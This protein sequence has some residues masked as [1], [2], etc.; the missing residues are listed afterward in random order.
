[1]RK[2]TQL[3]T[4]LLLTALTP[5][6]M[7]ADHS[8]FYRQYNAAL[9]IS[10]P[11]LKLERFLQLLEKYP[12]KA[13]ELDLMLSTLSKGQKVTPQMQQSAEN[14][15]KHHGGNP[16][17]T[18]IALKFI[19]AE[20]QQDEY[21]KNFFR[22]C[23]FSALTPSEWQSV[24]PIAAQHTA[25]HIRNNSCSREGAAIYRPVSAIP[26]HLDPRVRFELLYHALYLFWNG[27]WDEH[28]S[29]ANF[30]RW[31]TLPDSGCKKYYD[32]TLN[33]LIALEEVLPFPESAALLQVYSAHCLKRAGIYAE[34]FTDSRNGAL[35]EQ[36]YEAAIVSRNRKLL[37]I[38][39]KLEN[40]EFGSFVL[41]MYFDDPSKL[42]KFF[43]PGDAELIRSVWKKDFKTAEKYAAGILSSGTVTSP[44]TVRAMLDMIWHT[45]NKVML[46]QIAAAAEKNP[47]QLLLPTIANAIAYNFAVLN[48]ELDRAEKLLKTALNAEPKNPAYLDSMAYLL[49]RKKQFK[50][51]RSFIRLA[52]KFANPAESQSTI[53]LHAAEIELAATNDKDA[54]REYLRKAELA[55]KSEDSE[56]DYARAGELKQELEK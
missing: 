18:V 14:L 55:A 46:K 23:D 42:D 16:A 32:D 21:R 30:D 43:Q 28:C 15:L 38:V 34:K 36:L 47:K 40:S 44:W 10:V 13:A 52:L 8:R 4:L 22:K 20:K 54:A 26:E 31:Q 6:V 11:A 45:R 49:Y 17:V 7:A 41:T 5:P 53:L 39:S 3:T 35:R 25:Y 51:A 29:A 1:M 19:P 9:D 12:E 2:I 48:I 24:I 33:K 50:R 56:Y 37:S 27:A